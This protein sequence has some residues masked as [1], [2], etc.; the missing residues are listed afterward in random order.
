M[1]KTNDYINLQMAPVALERCPQCGDTPFRPF[2][3]GQVRRGGV[4]EVGERF[5]ARLQDRL[6]QVHTVICARCK[7]VVGHE[8]VEGGSRSAKRHNEKIK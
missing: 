2:L 6:P 5:L 8:D 4:A 3:R 7:E 1:I